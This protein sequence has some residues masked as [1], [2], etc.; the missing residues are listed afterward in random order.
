MQER[1]KKANNSNELN[2]SLLHHDHLSRKSR[3]IFFFFL[4]ATRSNQWVYQGQYTKIVYISEV[5]WSENRSVVSD[6]LWP[7]GLYSP[8][9]SPGQNAGVGSL[10]L[11]Q[12]SSQPRD[13]TQVSCIASRFF[14]SWAQGKPK[15]T[16]ECSLSLLQQ[17]FLTQELNCGLLHCWQILYQLSYDTSNKKN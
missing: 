6:A 15:N 1:G 14:T 12:R 13:R 8:R 3:G 5:K 11:L 17:I 2:L 7:H 9:N 4:S 10:S 16:G